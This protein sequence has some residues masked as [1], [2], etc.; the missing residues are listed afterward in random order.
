MLNKKVSKIMNRDITNIYQSLKNNKLILLVFIILNIT[1]EIS[2]QNPI[3]RD[4]F[5]ADPSA[6]VFH[7][8]VYIYPS[9][10][11]SCTE[12]RG[13]IGWFCMKDYHVF[14]SEN[15]TEWTDHGMIVSSLNS[16]SIDLASL[17]Q[18]TRCSL[19]AE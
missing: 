19:R 12:N 1:I 17:Y 9:H 15:L 16:K 14:S 2:A 18:L 11:I 7:D 8:K 4:Q 10:D 5:T 13:R 6:R 3:I